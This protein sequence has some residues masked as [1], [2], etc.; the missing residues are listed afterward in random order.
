MGRP[1]GTEG[2][3]ELEKLVGSAPE[4]EVPAH[5]VHVDGFY[6]SRHE[7]TN[8]DYHRFVA[9]TGHPVPAGWKDGKIPP[10]QADFPVTGISWQDAQAYCAWLT[11]RGT[12]GVVFRLPTEAEWEYTAR[13]QDGRLFPWGNFWRD[14]LANTGQALG[15]GQTLLLPVNVEPNNTR[16]RSALGICGMGGQCL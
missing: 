14:G 1:A 3:V 8:A 2:L 16:D 15:S 7:T 4:D 12:G 11:Q 10:G 9:A 5:P 6:L 13:G